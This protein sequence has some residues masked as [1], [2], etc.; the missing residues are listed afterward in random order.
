MIARLPCSA[1]PGPPET[2]ASRNSRPVFSFSA[3]AMRFVASSSVVERSTSRPPRDASATP[4]G[5]SSAFST[6]AV[7]VTQTSSVSQRPATSA[8]E[9]A[10]STP[11]SAAAFSLSCWGS[12]PTTVRPQAISRRAM[13]PPI[14]PSPRIPTGSLIP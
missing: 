4:S 14:R 11:A 10:V 3:A 9:P 1:A 2:G 12:K 8:G 6:A 13:A 7:E 5:P